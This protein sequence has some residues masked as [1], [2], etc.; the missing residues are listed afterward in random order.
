V[1]QEEEEMAEDRDWNEHNRE[2]IALFRS[3]GGKAAN[4]TTPLVLLTTTGA[5]SGL[6]RT[7][8][9]NYT[10]D[11]DRVIVIASKAASPTHPDWYRN[12][13]AN[14]EVTVELGTEKFQARARTAEGEEHDRLFNQQA[15]LMPYFAKYQQET[16]RKIPVVILERI[17]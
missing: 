6:P 1:I 5:K 8:P 16:K 14:P 7:N 17:S 10:L 11:G 15:A 13:I 9:L 12:L 3:N 4:G 2:V